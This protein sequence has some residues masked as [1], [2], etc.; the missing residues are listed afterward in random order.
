M[1]DFRRDLPHA[2]LVPLPRPG[3]Q[4]RRLRGGGPLRPVLPDGPGGMGAD[5]RDR[6]CD[7]H[8]APVA[9]ELHADGR[10]ASVIVQNQWHRP[11]RLVPLVLPLAL[12]RHDRLPESRAPGRQARSCCAT[13]FP[14]SGASW[15]RLACVRG[16]ARTNEIELTNATPS[17]LPVTLV[18][19]DEYAYD[20]RPSIP[21]STPAAR[22]GRHRGALPSA[23]APRAAPGAAGAV[24]AG[25]ANRSFAPYR[26]QR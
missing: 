11:K 7:Q 10:P 17:A 20:G 15:A 16:T 18:L 5:P 26:R 6:A 14:T 1:R 4:P 25:H 3:R 19:R 12:S 24:R 23:A 13:S 21:T 2:G 8:A 22:R 9:A